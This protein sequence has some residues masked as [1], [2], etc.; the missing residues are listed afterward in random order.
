[1]QPK[2]IGFYLV[3]GYA[4]MSTAAA[5]E[6][7]RAA[8]LLSG[9]PLYDIVPLSMSGGMAMAS[10]P[11]GIATQPIDEAPGPFDIMFVVAGG[12]P[13]RIHDPALFTWLRQLDRAGT[14]LGGI[15]GGGVILARAGVMGNRR[16]TVHWHHM[17]DLASQLPRLLVEQ[18]L[19]VIDRDRYTCA[20]GTAPLDMIC[21]IVAADHGSGFARSISNWFI[22]AQ[23]RPADAP[24]QSSVEARFGALPRPVLDALDLMESHI[25]DPLSL[26]QLGA[27]VGLSPRQ[28][29]RHFSETVGRPVMK[30]YLSLRLE[31]AQ[32]LLTDTRL[33]ISQIAHLT[34][35]SSAAH[36]SDT[37]R[38]TMGE[39]PRDAR[40]RLR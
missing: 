22:Q 23:I 4:L 34:G 35:F 18:R 24:Q 26:A 16:M 1:M 30:A 3:D 28:L 12:D 10:L 33:P 20:G 15:S 21:A 36:F 31:T 19:Y 25:A 32:R 39:S 37:Y 40:G 13:M 14:A 38:R 6:P 2:R 5:M 9:R 7:L 29:Q 27:L 8:N 17:A 11:A